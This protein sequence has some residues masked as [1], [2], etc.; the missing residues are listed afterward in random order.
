MKKY[1]EDPDQIEKVL[2]ENQQFDP[3][4]RCKHQHRQEEPN[5]PKDKL[6]PLV[7]GHWSLDI[8]YYL[9]KRTS[10]TQC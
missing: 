6:K 3:H 9:E 2:D 5:K 7:I 8:G 10:N 4:L 1:V